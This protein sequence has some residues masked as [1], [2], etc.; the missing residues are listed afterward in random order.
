MET[1]LSCDW[2]TSAFRLRLVRGSD[3]RILAEITHT[4]G[5][6][7]TYRRWTEAGCPPRQVFYASLLAKRITELA[8]KSGDPLNGIPVVLSGMASSSI[9]MKEL[10]YQKLPVHLDGSDLLVEHFDTEEAKNPLLVISG[11]QT[12]DDVMRGEETKIVGC[13]PMLKKQEAPEL[14]ILPG[15]HSKHMV[16]QQHKAVAF[17]TYMT[18][19]FF[20]LLSVDSVLSASIAAD[21]V[22]EPA[23]RV[24]FRKG[25]RA[26]QESGL[27][28]AAFLVRTNQLLKNTPKEANFH[29]LS[30]LLIGAELTDIPRNMPVYL[31]AGSVHTPLYRAALEELDVK[32]H[33]GMDAD[34]A[35]IAGQYMTLSRY[36]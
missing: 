7:D 35:L 10:P 12:D 24:W 23:H 28:H 13:L 34:E 20:K 30:G 17:K 29:Y 31:V 33:G 32:I 6:A 2:G 27:L 9:G 11:V 8:R 16:V 15:T 36:Y 21:F 26:A 19:E 3:L 25:V 18:G 4:T 1:F 22:E 5:V 14:I